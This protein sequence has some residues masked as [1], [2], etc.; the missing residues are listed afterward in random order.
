MKALKQNIVVLY[1]DVI[2]DTKN[3]MVYNEI[4]ALKQNTV[5]LYKI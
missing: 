2:T 5:V 4:K 1:W 3:F